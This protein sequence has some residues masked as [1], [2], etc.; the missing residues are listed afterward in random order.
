MNKEHTSSSKKTRQGF[1]ITATDTGIGKTV[2]TAA[3]ALAMKQKN[4]NV[5]VMKPIESGVHPSHIKSSDAE[6]L[7]TLVT[8]SRSFESICLYQFTDPLAP[9]A[10]A[11]KA[12]VAID[13]NS[14]SST[15]TRVA[16]EHDLV[17]IEGVGGLMVPLTTTQTV[18][19]LINILQL[20]CVVVG[21]TVLGGVNHILLTLEVLEKHNVV[22]AAIVLNE[23]SPMGMS[24]TDQLQQQSTVALIKEL[25][26]VPVFGP[27][28][29]D[30]E[31]EN[32][33]ITGVKRLS[34]HASIQELATHLSENDA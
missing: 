6:R 4:L 18:C 16:K 32:D 26:K 25:T 28:R 12:G 3:L 30:E 31:V 23:G 11:R 7:R 34:T 20:S 27:L 10:A 19:D 33:W 13:L 24:E 8:P 22:I 14:I 2:V 21:R 29:Y 5:G 1:F 15:C 9:L 17:L